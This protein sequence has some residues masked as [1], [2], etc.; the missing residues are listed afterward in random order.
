MFVIRYVKQE[1]GA[2]KAARQAYEDY[3]KFR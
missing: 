2:Y 3:E 1:S